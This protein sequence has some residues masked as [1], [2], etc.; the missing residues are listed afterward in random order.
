MCVSIVSI[1]QLAFLIGC[2]NGQSNI[3]DDAFDDFG[4]TSDFMNNDN[5]GGSLR[6]SRSSSNRDRHY[7]YYIF[8][9]N[10]CHTDSCSSSYIRA[11]AKFSMISCTDGDYTSRIRSSSQSPVC[12]CCLTRHLSDSERRALNG[13]LASVAPVTADYRCKLTA[14]NTEVKNTNSLR[15]ENAR[16]TNEGDSCRCCHNVRLSTLEIQNM[17]RDLD[18]RFG[19]ADRASDGLSGNR[20]KRQTKD[21]TQLSCNGPQ[22]R[23][24]KRMDS[25]IINCL[26]V[27]NTDNCR[28]CFNQSLPIMERIKYEYELAEKIRVSGSDRGDAFL[29]KSLFSATDDIWLDTGR[30]S[31]GNMKRSPAYGPA[32]FSPSSA[33]TPASDINAWLGMF[34]DD[35]TGA[36]PFPVSG[37]SGN[38]YGTRDINGQ[39]RCR[40]RK[41]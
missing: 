25:F 27:G 12:R 15:N 23:V 3:F 9:R 30:R 39:C 41:R 19:T 13:H 11:L 10:K 36:T 38:S 8:G 28:C 16:C 22:V 33:S 31:S 2:A 40:C 5:G 18:E 34:G 32:A 20:N 24:M 37:G 4:F 35:S 29:D 7:N 26:R 1:L 21:C 14:C 6:N 17:Q